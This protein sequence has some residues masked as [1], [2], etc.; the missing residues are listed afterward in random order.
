MVAH[1]H[2][3]KPLGD[4]TNAERKARGLERLSGRLQEPGEEALLC[5]RQPAG[6]DG[7]PPNTLKLAPRSL[8]G[9]GAEG[10]GAT[11]GS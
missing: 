5:C 9:A 11:G 2:P 1:R 4:G 6:Q 8:P 10:T 3:E 7:G